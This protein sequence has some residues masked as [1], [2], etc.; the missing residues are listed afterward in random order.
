MKTEFIRYTISAIVFGLMVFV[1]GTLMSVLKASLPPRS[2][3]ELPS[4][5][6]MMAIF[7]AFATV[8]L[9]PVCLANVAMD[10]LGFAG[11]LTAIKRRNRQTN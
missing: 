9:L 5:F 8:I 1:A 7:L 3:F 11:P 6:E 2:I 10:L 4:I